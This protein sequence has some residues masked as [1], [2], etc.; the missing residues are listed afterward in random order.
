MNSICFPRFHTFETA[1]P[2]ELMSSYELM[3]LMEREWWEENEH[4]PHT[5]CVHLTEQARS[6]TCI[7]LHNF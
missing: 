1:L 7:L 2:V 3:T 6:F 5:L 4:L